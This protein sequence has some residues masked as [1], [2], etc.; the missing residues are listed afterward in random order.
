MNRII[1][2]TDILLPFV[3]YLTMVIMSIFLVPDFQF[4]NDRTAAIVTM[5]I[6][7]FPLMTLGIMYLVSLCYLQDKKQYS[8]YHT[9]KDLD[10]FWT[11][12][13]TDKSEYFKFRDELYVT[14]ITNN[15]ITVYKVLL[16]RFR[17][18][19]CG[20]FSNT[21]NKIEYQSGL[22]S[23]LTG[24]ISRDIKNKTEKRLHKNK[25][26]NYNNLEE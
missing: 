13:F 6:L 7:L 4:S 5:S 17:H 14:S 22:K 21:D 11:L 8:S 2:L 10:R 24:F 1:K 20:S 19:Y 23:T 25:Y 26:A 18:I 9:Y 16:F 15:T 3:I 12:Y